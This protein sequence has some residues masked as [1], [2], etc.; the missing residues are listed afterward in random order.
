[1]SKRKKT[2]PEYIKAVRRFLQSLA[3]AQLDAEGAR[4]SVFK[5]TNITKSS[6]E[7]MLYRGEGGLD[8]WVELLAHLYHISPQQ[9]VALLAESKNT[10]KKSQ[11]LTEGQILFSELS[12]Q[13]SED[14]R[15]FW[16]SVIHTAEG[17]KAPVNVKKK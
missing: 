4:E 16:A 6:L 10:L 17:I 2:Q 3:K 12:D 11:K 5:K 14:K 15:H 7:A 8:S 13:L 9:I 1:M